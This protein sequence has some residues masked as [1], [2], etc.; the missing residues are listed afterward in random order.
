MRCTCSMNPRWDCIPATP[1]G[2]SRC[3]VGCATGELRPVVEH[4]LAAIR[5]ADF[6]L[7]L[8]P[9]AANM[10][11]GW[12]TPAGGRGR[13]L[14][15][16]RIPH[17]REAHRCAERPASRGSPLDQDPGRR[18]PQPQGRRCGYPAGTLTAITGVSGSG[19]STWSTTS[20]TETWK[21]GCTGD[22]RPSRIWE[23]QSERSRR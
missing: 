5:Q 10:A 8:G 20:C 19:K 3:C 9:A 4:D 12:S 1:T 17:R 22:T 13:R 21:P 15:H 11:E 18:A 23:R 16:R 2:C 14:S 7:E 6:M